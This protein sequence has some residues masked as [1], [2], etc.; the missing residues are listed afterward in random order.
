MKGILR[1]I[2]QILRDN[3]QEVLA[4]HTIQVSFLELTIKFSLI[5]CTFGPWTI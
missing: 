1:K 4:I 2:T 3:S 5:F